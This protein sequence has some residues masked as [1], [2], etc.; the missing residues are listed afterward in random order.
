M[1]ERFMRFL[2]DEWI[3]RLDDETEI[4]PALLQESTVAACHA[5]CQQ[6]L[7]PGNLQRSRYISAISIEREAQGHILRSGKR[8]KLSRK[9]S[10][11]FIS[12]CS[13]AERSTIIGQSKSRQCSL[14]N[15]H[16]MHKLDRDMLRI[17]CRCAI[18]K[19]EQAASLVKTPRHRPTGLCNASYF[20]RKKGFGN[21]H[22][23]LEAC[24]D[25]RLQIRLFSLRRHRFLS[26]NLASMEHIQF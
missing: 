9:W 16:R 2:N 26:F 22:A 11:C 13:T 25:Q 14:A 20:S 7:F 24:R 5:K 12:T 8:I 19:G 3:A 18:T 10:A 4:Q 1:V 21:G 15:N 23:L 6:P 17:G